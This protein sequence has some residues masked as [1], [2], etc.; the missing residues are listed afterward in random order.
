MH[1]EPEPT[2]DT[3]K[4]RTTGA[5]ALESS[6]NAQGG[7]KF[8]S[9]TSGRVLDRR[10]WTILPITNDVIKHVD[11]LARKEK[12]FEFRNRNME[13]MDD[14]DSEYTDDDSEATGV[15]SDSDDDTN[16]KILENDVISVESDDSELNR[17]DS[18]ESDSSE[19]EDE[20]TEESDD[21]DDDDP[22][23][24]SLQ[25]ELNRAHQEFDNLYGEYE[26]DNES[27]ND[28]HPEEN[29]P[30]ESEFGDNMNEP[31]IEEVV[32]DLPNQEII[33]RSGRRVK[34]TGYLD[35]KPDF[36]N[37]KYES[38]NL[39]IGEEEANKIVFATCC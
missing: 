5:I 11:E 15:D 10:A 36:S 24:R 8:L 37:T 34:K 35:Y 22:D 1:E 26:G 21:D 32:G 6:D 9:L 4:Y 13:L 25:S 17:E 28:Y 39:T 23:E 3:G 33:T 38:S 19:V 18:L 12:P 7:W 29:E 30:D 31:N 16:V 14:D 20:S 2:N 27:N